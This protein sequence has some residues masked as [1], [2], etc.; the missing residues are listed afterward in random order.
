MA[1]PG[2]DYLRIGDAERDKM[3]ES[4][5]E[6]FA[7]GR[8]T[9]EELDERL[10]AALAA[11]TVG[12][13]RSIDR[14]LPQ[15]AP[16]AP[17]YQPGMR[18]RRRPFLFTFPL[19]ALTLLVFGAVTHTWALFAVARVFFVLWLLMTFLGFRRARRWHRHHPPAFL[20]NNPSWHR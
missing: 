18:M 2:P 6:H 15:P 17:A 3:T 20:G 7:Q 14:D 12:E 13:L 11:K 19:F 8:L 1:A 16:P 5:H 4:L 10:S 9:A